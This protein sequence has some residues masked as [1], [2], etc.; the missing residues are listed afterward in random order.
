MNRSSYGSNHSSGGGGGGGGGGG[1]GLGL[2]SDV[3][4]IRIEHIF[5][6]N[7]GEKW[8]RPLRKSIGQWL[9][10]C[11]E[12]AESFRFIAVGIGSYFFLLGISK[13]IAAGNNQRN[14]DGGSGTAHK[15]S[16]SSGGGTSKDKK[17][18]SDNASVRSSRTNRSS[19]KKSEKEQSSELS[20]P[21]T[22]TWAIEDVNSGTNIGLNRSLP[23][24]IPEES[25]VTSSSDVGDEG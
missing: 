1:M 3:E 11:M 13:V 6:F 16:K 7:L 23:G 10:I 18:T 20:I 15:S 5:T 4:T 8:E 14:D 2:L 9:D 21:N 17:S 25:E 22:I 12:Y 19:K 24:T